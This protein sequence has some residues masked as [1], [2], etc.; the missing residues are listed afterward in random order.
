MHDQKTDIS[1]RQALLTGAGAAMA[2]LLAGALST[3]ARA[4]APMLGADQPAHYRFKLGGF[5][6]TTI[7]DGAI[8]LKGPHPIFGQNVPEADVHAL[9]KENFL[10][11]A[12][13]E[14]GF[15]PVVVNTGSLLVLFDTGNGAGRRP[16]AGNTAATLAKAGYHP[17]QIDVVVITHFH[18]DHIGGMMEDGKP[19]YP[20]ARYITGETEY[21]F[22]SPKE[23]AEGKLA[24]VG[25]LVQ[26]NVVPFAEKISFLK[27]DGAIASGITAI[28]A[29]GH[30]PGHMAYHLESEGRRLLLWADT[31]NH[32]VAS[33]QR[34]DWHVRFD[35]DKAAA[36]QTR[37]DILGMAAADKIPCA[38][39]HMPFPSVGFVENRAGA[40]HWVPVSYQLNL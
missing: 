15:A 10:P 18:P 39:Y 36:A 29:F 28:K 34:P 32:Y 13:F 2:P 25:K 14:I 12:N 40:Y 11:P 16:N 1:R 6:V 9:A 37:K 3:P 33:L 20:N 22:W 5:E 21:N 17:E 31:T 38:G 27:P 35:M 23:M 26:S 30:T 4:A 7:L 24:R 19:A 8:Q